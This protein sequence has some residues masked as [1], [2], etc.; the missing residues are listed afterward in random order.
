MSPVQSVKRS[1]RGRETR[2]KRLT[3]VLICCTALSLV[4]T[5]SLVSAFPLPV[6]FEVNFNSEDRS[7]LLIQG[8]AT[9]TGD[10]TIFPTPN[11]N[12]SVPFG[13]RVEF[14]DR[15]TKG[16]GATVEGV[17]GDP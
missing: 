5:D 9:S 10:P 4:V 3:V 7:S 12:I 13:G 6:G 8:P 11:G 1:K 17:A 16:G 15:K 2:M 14:M